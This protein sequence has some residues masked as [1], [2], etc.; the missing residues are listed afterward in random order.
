[1][2]WFLLLA[3]VACD[4]GERPDPGPTP[5]QLQTLATTSGGIDASPPDA[6]PIAEPE[7]PAPPPLP[8]IAQN[9]LDAVARAVL[10]RHRRDPTNTPDGTLAKRHTPLLVASDVNSG[11]VLSSAA[12]PSTEFELRTMAELQDEANRTQEKIF[13]IVISDV[14]I[15]GADANAWVGVTFLKPTGMKGHALCCCSANQ[16]FVKHGKAWRYKRTGMQVCS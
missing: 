10:E 9:D 7:P 14:A 8:S 5:L 13:F 16:M 3:L 12:L 11:R 2:R 1:V 4:A 6:P 15:T